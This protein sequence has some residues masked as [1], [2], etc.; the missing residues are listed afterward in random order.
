MA[1]VQILKKPTAFGLLLGN[2]SSGRKPDLSRGAANKHVCA[3]Y[4]L[5]TLPFLYLLV[6]SDA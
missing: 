6:I 3:C 2:S 4:L 5:L 1:S